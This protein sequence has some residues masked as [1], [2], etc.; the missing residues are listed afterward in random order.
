MD[1]LH[2]HHNTAC[3]RSLS[4][5]DS[6]ALPPRKDWPDRRSSMQNLDLVS[7]P[8]S[9]VPRAEQ[10]WAPECLAEGP[11]SKPHLSPPLDQNNLLTALSSSHYFSPINPLDILQSFAALAAT[12][13]SPIFCSL[14][15]LC[16]LW[17]SVTGGHTSPEYS[18]CT[19]RRGLSQSLDGY[20]LL[21]NRADPNRGFS[22]IC[23]QLSLPP[24]PK[25]EEP[26]T[27]CVGHWTAA[28]PFQGHYAMV[29]WDATG[30]P[31]QSRHGKGQFCNLHVPGHSL[32][33]PCGS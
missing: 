32:Q 18:E 23:S 26:G 19:G 6:L 31:G 10:E 17:G 15:S 28:R 25:K 13:L 24:P 8:R 9:S 33:K 5:T 30:S 1:I 16:G 27:Q 29:Q 11:G 2:L 21:V 3:S 12:P 14:G 22:L 20:E 4:R 7:E